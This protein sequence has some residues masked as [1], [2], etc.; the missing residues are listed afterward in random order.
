VVTDEQA[1]KSAIADSTASAAVSAANWFRLQHRSAIVANAFT[2]NW[3]RLQ[4]L[5]ATAAITASTAAAG[6]AQRH[7]QSDM[8]QLWLH[9]AGCFFC[10]HSYLIILI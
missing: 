3:F 5:S 7:N 10:K 1:K 8:A 6:A 4:H 2:A 9:R